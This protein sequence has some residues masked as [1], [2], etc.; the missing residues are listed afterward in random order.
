MAKSTKLTSFCDN[1]VW[2]SAVRFF[3]RKILYVPWLNQG[4]G[5][6]DDQSNDSICVV[7]C[8]LILK[9]VYWLA[10]MLTYASFVFILCTYP[11]S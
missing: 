9:N 7:V 5:L 2:R 10:N 3:K 6:L 8:V 1:I 11:M 4:C